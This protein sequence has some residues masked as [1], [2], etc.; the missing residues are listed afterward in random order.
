MRQQIEKLLDNAPPGHIH[1]RDRAKIKTQ[2]VKV[3]KLI[4]DLGRQDERSGKVSIDEQSLRKL[5]R[6][7]APGSEGA[8]VQH[9]KSLPESNITNRGGLKRVPWETVA[10]D[11]KS[12]RPDLPEESEQAGPRL[13][14]YSSQLEIRTAVQSQAPNIPAE[15]FDPD[16][17]DRRARGVF[18]SLGV[19][20]DAEAVSSNIWDCMVRKLGWFAATMALVLV[21]LIIMCYSAAVAATG[22]AAAVFWPSFW[23]LFWSF[24]VPAFGATNLVATVVLI[25]A[26]IANPAG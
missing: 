2:A 14:P 24:A 25:V 7:V 26:C 12:H 19:A 10:E 3:A 20:E 8:V 4:D 23:T 18:S 1:P 5:V 21:A 6:E 16:R 9:L 17:W 11:F 15:A 13:T 22:G